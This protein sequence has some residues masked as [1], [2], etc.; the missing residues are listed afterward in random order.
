MSR[1]SCHSIYVDYDGCLCPRHDDW[2]DPLYFSAPNSQINFMG[3]GGFISIIK[4]VV[5][6]SHA[7]SSFATDC[8][9]VCASSVPNLFIC[10]CLAPRYLNSAAVLKYEKHLWFLNLWD[11]LNDS[12]LL[13]QFSV[14]LKYL[15]TFIEQIY[16]HEESAGAG[17]KH[18]WIGLSKIIQI[19][20]W[21]VRGSISIPS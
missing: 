21:Y 12:V 9:T 3:L 13:L 14:S 7:C 18:K 1:K 8:C 4:M 6:S 5:C 19:L 11:S 2:S 16:L 15:W 10:F 17:S 20:F